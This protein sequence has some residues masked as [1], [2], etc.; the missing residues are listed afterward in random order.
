MMVKDGC[1]GAFR[2]ISQGLQGSQGRSGLGR[3]VRA[4]GW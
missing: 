2:V 1:A 3:A 4:M